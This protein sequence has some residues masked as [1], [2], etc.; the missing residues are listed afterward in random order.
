[1]RDQDLNQA[2]QLPRKTLR[3]TPHKAAL[4]TVAAPFQS[5]GSKA[6]RANGGSHGAADVAGG[7]QYSAEGRE[8]V[9][10]QGFLN[11]VGHGSSEAPGR[12]LDRSPRACACA[13]ARHKHSLRTGIRTVGDALKTVGSPSEMNPAPLPPS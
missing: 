11:T 13:P 12:A 7:Q 3:C 10:S 4:D 5:G 6:E 2:I 1:M 9:V 8:A